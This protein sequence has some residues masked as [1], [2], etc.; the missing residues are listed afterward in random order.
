MLLV[1]KHIKSIH[2]NKKEKEIKKKL[3]LEGIKKGE[4]ILEQKENLPR[5]AT[6]YRSNI[7]NKT[8]EITIVYN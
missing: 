5:H 6:F 3:N 7:R 2:L 4:R 8:F 1:C